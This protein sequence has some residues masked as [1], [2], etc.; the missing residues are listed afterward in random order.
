MRKEKMNVRPVAQ[1]HCRRKRNG[2]NIFKAEGTKGT[3]RVEER[4]YSGI[5]DLRLRI[6]IP[7]LP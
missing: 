1:K 2:Q 7:G 5:N 4:N 3:E 6:R